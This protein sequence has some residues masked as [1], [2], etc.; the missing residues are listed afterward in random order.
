M[1]FP[2]NLEWPNFTD[3]HNCVVKAQTNHSKQLSILGIHI[4]IVLSQ[5]IYFM[6]CFQVTFLLNNILYEAYEHKNICH[7]F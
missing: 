3:P 2:R 7:L 5:L 4:F 6:Y 1:T